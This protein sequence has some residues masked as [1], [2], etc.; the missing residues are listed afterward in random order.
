M[1]GEPYL[2]LRAGD[3]IEA[4]CRNVCTKCSSRACLYANNFGISQLPKSGNCK[5]CKCRRNAGRT[6]CRSFLLI[7][8]I[9]FLK[10]IAICDFN[11]RCHG[12]LFQQLWHTNRHSIWS[13]VLRTIA[14]LIK[15]CLQVKFNNKSNGLCNYHLSD[16]RLVDGKLSL[17]AR[18]VLHT[19]YIS[20]S[21]DCSYFWRSACGIEKFA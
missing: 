19:W 12:S 15:Y 21:F 5:F 1:G 9:S 20:H 6:I 2:T 7:S 13:F 8:W 16:S 11:C 3:R 10:W 18:S 14:G 17:G 4:K